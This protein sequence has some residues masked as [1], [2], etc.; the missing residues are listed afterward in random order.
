MNITVEIAKESEEWDKYPEVN[1]QLFADITSLVLSRYPNLACLEEV[2]LSI[3]LAG[4]EQIQQLNKQFRNIDKATNVLSFPDQEIDWREIVE[5]VTDCNYIYLGDIAF[6]I[7]VII[8]EAQK[9]SIS[10]QDHF[11]HLLLHA[12]LHLLGYNHI[13]D[14]EAQVMESLEIEIL[15]SIGIKSPYLT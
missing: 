9:Q 1:K 6:C 4:N 7:E 5:F 14:N 13:E 12:L 8:L 10:F 2:E 3:L 11:K 15:E